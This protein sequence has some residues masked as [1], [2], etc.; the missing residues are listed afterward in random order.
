MGLIGDH[1]EKVNKVF[2]DWR[3]A[4]I[5]PVPK[6]V[7]IDAGEIILLGRYWVVC[8]SYNPLRG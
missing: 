3:D 4:V 5:I 1:G 8:I 2:Q 6:K 7:I